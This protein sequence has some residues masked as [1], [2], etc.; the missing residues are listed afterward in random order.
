MIQNNNRHHID[1]RYANIG[2]P[3]RIFAVPSIHGDLAKLNVIHESIYQ[4]FQPGDRLVY[5]GNYTGYGDYSR[6]TIDALL[7]FRRCLLS[8]SGVQVN[9]ITYIRG[10]QEEMWK[11]LMQLQFAPNP[12]ETLEW[13]MDKGMAQTMDSYGLCLYE[14][15]RVAREG[16]IR[17]SRWTDKVRQ[18]VYGNAGHDIF[19]ASL[20]RAVFTD[21]AYTKADGV[22]SP[23][24]FVNAGIDFSKSLDDQGDTLWWGNS[25]FK[26]MKRAYAPYQKIIRGF[27]PED[28]GFEETSIT[29]TLDDGC[30]RGGN[31]LYAAMNSIGDIVDLKAA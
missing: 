16:I 1:C 10:I 26:S 5:L 27:D 18:T 29:T 17:L 21:C 14:A 24:L 20:K 22:C 6:Q 15:S 19:N 30:G 25:H 4:H 9:D 12:S 7:N 8:I 28:G 31:L 2:S 23:L 3:N 13:M 11:K